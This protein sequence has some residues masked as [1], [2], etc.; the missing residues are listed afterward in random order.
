[1]TFGEFKA[2]L[3]GFENVFIDKGCRSHPNIEQWELIKEK[4]NEVVVP[5][6]PVPTTYCPS[7]WTVPPTDDQ[8]K[9][10]LPNTP[11]FTV[12]TTAPVFDQYK[13]YSP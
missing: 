10:P 5:T 4:L 8:G 1:M 2:W 12:S 11:V 6:L 9:Y 13:P 7:T 3:D